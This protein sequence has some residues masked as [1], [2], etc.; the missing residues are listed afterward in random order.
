MTINFYEVAAYNT[1]TRET[2]EQ[3]FCDGGI[4]FDEVV[5]DMK[6]K[7]REQHPAV[8]IHILDCPQ[9]LDRSHDMIIK[10][11]HTEND[12]LEGLDDN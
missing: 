3:S 2:V 8:I 10:N 11:F 7:H 12:K 4:E 6:F 5:S 1:I 9:V